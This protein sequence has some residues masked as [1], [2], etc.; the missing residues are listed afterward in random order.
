MGVK[1]L[2]DSI[3]DRL[4]SFMEIGWITLRIKTQRGKA[5]IERLSRW[6]R[7]WKLWNSTGVCIGILML[8]LMAIMFAIT[9]WVTVHATPEPTPAHEPR[10]VVAVPGVNDLMP[11]ELTPYILFSLITAATVHE[12]GH[13]IAARVADIDVEEMGAIFLGPIPL[14]A[15]VLPDYEAVNAASTA[16]KLRIYC[17]GVMNN[18]ALFVLVTPVLLASVTASPVDIAEAYST[19]LNTTGTE[20]APVLELGPVTNT[21]AWIWF[22]NLNLALANMLPILA[23]DGGHVVSTIS[24]WIAGKLGLGG[25]VNV[26]ISADDAAT[27]A[28]S[29][30]M[31]AVVGVSLFG[32]HLL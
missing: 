19:A 25:E 4:P 2:R 30:V 28:T 5:T 1:Q 9:A 7:F 8:L 16:A 29:V 15:Y 21:I 27:I 13:A 32:P 23:L 11:L 10:N 24:E 20:I 3:N 31:I 26:T 22:L 12:L 17:A 6:E 18:V 14:G